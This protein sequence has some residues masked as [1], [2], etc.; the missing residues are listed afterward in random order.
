MTEAEW[1]SCTDPEAMLAFLQGKASDRKL[2]LFACAC[3][4]RIG[5]DLPDQ[6]SWNAVL[7]AEVY[8]DR[9]VSEQDL[10]AAR[11]E[12]ERSSQINMAAYGA[13]Q[14]TAMSAWEAATGVIDAVYYLAWEA[15][16][17]GEERET[18]QTSVLR[19]IFGP[20][21]FRLITIDP[22]WLQW[23]WGTV[24]SIARHIY[25]EHAFHDLPILADALT[26]AG[27]DNQELID[28]CRTDGPHV[29]GCWVVDLLLGRD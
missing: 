8:A 28:H 1:L 21:P 9:G 13:V 17:E 18:G 7:V 25:D 26:D 19:D 15:R 12:A 5:A 24:S 3:C 27:C 16:E 22:G 11:T 20:L 4:R 10:A 14:A 6:Q 2:R 29:R 23:N